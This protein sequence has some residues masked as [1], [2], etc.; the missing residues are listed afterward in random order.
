[1]RWYLEDMFMSRTVK[2]RRIYSICKLIVSLSQFYGCWQNAE[3][4]GSE[5]KTLLTVIAISAEYHHLHKF[6]YP[7]FSQTAR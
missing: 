6:L 3:T 1:M 5:T 2:G 7:Q 4:P